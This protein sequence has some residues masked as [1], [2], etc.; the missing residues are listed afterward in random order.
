M[1][2]LFIYFI[3]SCG[4]LYVNGQCSNTTYSAVSQTCNRNPN[5]HN[6]CQLG[7]SCRN[8]AVDTCRLIL[9][10]MACDGDGDCFAPYDKCV[11]GN[12]TQTKYPGDYCRVNEDCQS[13][14]CGSS[15]CQGIGNR[16][17]C[18]FND[19]AI[20][21]PGLFCNKDSACQAQLIENDICN[22]N[23]GGIDRGG[24]GAN[25]YIACGPGLYC[26]DVTDK[27]TRYHNIAPGQPCGDTVGCQVGL[28]CYN[29]VCRTPDAVTGITCQ[30]DFQ[31][32]N[33]VCNCTN[34][35]NQ[36]GVCDPTYLDYSCSDQEF[37]DCMTQYGCPNYP[38][39]PFVKGTC[40]NQNCK[41]AA[42]KYTRC[43]YK[44][45]PSYIAG[46][47]AYQEDYACTASFTY[48]ATLL[49]LIGI[50]IV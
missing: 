17:P 41:C 43:L 26:D 48:V 35:G 29:D 11:E 24:N 23:V 8:E 49:V 27:C 50:L 18:R 32:V 28:I 38:S 13:G 5:N 31:C 4:F 46:G 12:C 20:C 34:G 42:V 19:L 16:L 15:V 40:A 44:N 33:S 1:S 2:W 45:I 47:F 3:A 14:S 10:G 21:A 30:A 39:A 9:E 7:L 37:L 22:G 6:E 25:A 36:A